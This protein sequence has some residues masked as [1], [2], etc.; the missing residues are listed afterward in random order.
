MF[1]Q[2]NCCACTHRQ[3]ELEFWPVLWMFVWYIHCL[4]NVDKCSMYLKW[5][6]N[7]YIRKFWFQVKLFL[8]RQDNLST[9]TNVTNSI[10]PMN[11][12]R[13]INW[14]EIF[15]QFSL[16]SIKI[17]VMVLFQTGCVFTVTVTVGFFLQGPTL[18]SIHKH[19]GCFLLLPIWNSH[20]WQIFKNDRP[21]DD[22]TLRSV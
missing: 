10:Q 16:T 3:K 5:S 19:R 1:C 13:R 20:Q 17:S 4:L 8:F 2:K 15:Y 12:K 6:L 22:C 11:I 14:M 21:W 18:F 9:S 7:E